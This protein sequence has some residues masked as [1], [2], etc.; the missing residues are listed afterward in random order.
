[1]IE[2]QVIA[3]CLRKDFWDKAKNILSK[4]MFPKEYSTIFDTITSSQQKYEVDLTVDELLA[5]HRDRYPAMPEST[6]N[7]IEEEIENLK[8]V[9][10]TNMSMAFDLLFNLWRRDKAREIGDKALAIWTGQ[11]DDFGVLQRIIDSAIKE[12]PE[13][14]ETFTIIKDTLKDLIANETKTCDFKFPLKPL[15]NQVMGLNKGDLGIIFARP[16]VGK[17]SFC[18][19]L[20]SEYVKAGHKV[21]YWANE[22]RA[23]RLKIRM[24]CS[25]LNMSKDD[26]YDNVESCS[27]KLQDMEVEE[28]LTVIDSVGTDISEI[29]SYCDLNKPDIIFI[30]QLDKIK[31]RGNFNRGDERLK[32]LYSSARE[33]AKRNECLVWAVSQAG[34][35]AEGK[36][37]IS[38]DMLDGSK[39]GKAG[40][41]DIIIGIGR[42]NGDYDLDPT[43][44]LTISKN[45]VNGVHSTVTC[46]MDVKTGVFKDFAE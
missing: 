39:T 26:L 28:K 41:G 1:V 35:D 22:E 37:I 10:P 23:T 5:L 15:Y 29:Q 20:A 27:N 40:E 24:F 31:V 2:K 4:D 25:L 6:R 34:A 43:R 33:I 45:K 18:C 12:D 46:E 16:E 3:L 17:T 44:F 38:Y 11:S 19:Y 32:E 14:H 36:Q 30:D 8:G 21:F 13:Q 7:N 9:A 42:N